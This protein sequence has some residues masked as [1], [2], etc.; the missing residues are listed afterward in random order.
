ML[1]QGEVSTLIEEEKTVKLTV[2]RTEEAVELIL[3]MESLSLEKSGEH[4][5][6]LKISDDQIPRLNQMLVSRGFNVSELSPQ[7][8]SLEDVFIRL[9]EGG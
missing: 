8:E 7:R 1:Y 9:T 4:S 3:Q 5:I 2:D 6:Y